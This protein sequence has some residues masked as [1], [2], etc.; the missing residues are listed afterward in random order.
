MRSGKLPSAQEIIC[1]IRKE[2]KEQLEHILPLDNQISLGRDEDG[3]TPL[4]IAV[5]CNN[6]DI[7]LMLLERN[8]DPNEKNEDGSTALSEVSSVEV[9]QALFAAGARVS[10]EEPSDGHTSVHNAVIMGYEKV[11][12]TLLDGDGKAALTILADGLYTPLH[13][14][15]CHSEASC[16]RML[17][18]SG[19]DPNLSGSESVE[20]SPIH[21]AVRRCSLP[22]LKMLHEEGGRLDISDLQTA[23]AF[24]KKEIVDY[25]KACLA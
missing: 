21:C 3:F 9:C 6:L 22:F 4:S 20:Y 1:L 5:S 23:E 2:Q 7:V 24:C 25:I 11:L 17:L 10:E 8:C 15:V 16:A 14:A 12:E 19:A 13:L 18:K